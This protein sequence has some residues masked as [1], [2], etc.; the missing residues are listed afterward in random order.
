MYQ[1]YVS[2]FSS[3]QPDEDVYLWGEGESVLFKRLAR[4]GLLPNDYAIQITAYPVPWLTALLPD[5]VPKLY[6]MLDMTDDWNL[7]NSLGSGYQEPWSVSLFLGDF[8]TFWDLDSAYQLIPMANGASGWVITTGS[9]ELV[10]DRLKSESWTRLE[11]KLTGENRGDIPISWDI[12]FGYRWEA[13]SNRPDSYTARFS[14]LNFQSDRKEWLYN[15]SVDVLL[16]WSLS[17]KYAGILESK[18]VIGKAYPWRGHL[19]GVNLGLERVKDYLEPETALP[20]G[21]SRNE[22]IIQPF[23]YMH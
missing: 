12:K 22:F 7:W 16:R 2:F 9:Q 8:A 10:N 11:W 20:S 14:V 15:H 13:S 3:F 21:K 5:N 6:S 17:K 4:N 23:I 19:V 1:S 18:V